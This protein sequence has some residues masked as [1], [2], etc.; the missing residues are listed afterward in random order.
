MRI[1]SI[2]AIIAALSACG[3]SESP[4]TASAKTLLQCS[5]D[6]DCK[7][8]RICDTGECKSPD[9]V[10]H[11]A[12]ID[13][14]TKPISQTTNEPAQNKMEK[15]LQ[16]ALIAALSQKPGTKERLGNAADAIL[17]YVNAGYAKIQP[18]H[19]WDYSDYR[20]LTKPTTFMG[21]TLVAIEEEY[22]R[23]WVG[24]CVSPGISVTVR[25]SQNG[26]SLD[27]FA[28]KNGCSVSRDTDEYYYPK[29][30]DI[31]LPAAPKGTYASLDCKERDLR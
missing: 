25:I 17:G 4:Q 6:T 28:S 21:H 11:I 13:T 5:K 19:R 1:F 8:D 27:A 16:D 10:S 30:E 14:E 23:E 20:I 24:C 22:M 26:D 12:Q 2:L 15:D 29:A 31:G 18:D 9:S 3:S 7:G